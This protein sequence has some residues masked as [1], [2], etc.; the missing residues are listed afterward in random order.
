MKRKAQTRQLSPL[1]FPQ[2]FIASPRYKENPTSKANSSILSIE[3]N[4]IRS[5][6][7]SPVRNDHALPQILVE[8]SLEKSKFIAISKCNY[9]AA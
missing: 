9:A 2:K 1:S 5:K 3:N 7:C 8:R 6:I 4:S